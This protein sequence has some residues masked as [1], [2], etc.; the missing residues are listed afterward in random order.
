[1][2]SPELVWLDLASHTCASDDSSR[3]T[4]CRAGMSASGR[5]HSDGMAKCNAAQGVESFAR[6]SVRY[7]HYST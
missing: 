6:G 2:T 5:L 4:L 1:M 3:R 7:Y